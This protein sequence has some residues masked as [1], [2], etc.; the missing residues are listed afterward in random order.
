MRPTWTARSRRS[1]GTSA[2]ASPRPT[3]SEY[4][5]YPGKGSYLAVFTATDDQGATTSDTVLVTITNAPPEVIS[6]TAPVRVAPGLARSV[7]G[8]GYDPGGTDTLSGVLDFGDGSATASAAPGES[9]EHA[10]A[11]PGTYTVTYTV[12]DGQGG[13][14]SGTTSVL[15]KALS[16]EAGAPRTA[17][18]GELLDL[19]PVPE[20]QDNAD[21]V[22]VDFGDGSAPLARSAG[23]PTPLTHVYRN[24]GTYTFSL[25]IRNGVSEFTDTTQVTVSNVAPVLTGV[26]ASG[27]VAPGSSASFQAFSSDAGLDDVLTTTWAFGDGATGTG[28]TVN[29]VFAAPGTYTVA[30]TVTDD[31]GAAVTSSRVVAVAAGS[32]SAAIDSR[33]TDF[34]LA[35]NQNYSA[36]P[37]LTFY[38]T[39][40]VAT[41]GVVE[42]PG[43]GLSTPFTVAAGSITAVSLA[44]EAQLIGPNELTNENKAI[45]VTAGAEVTVYGLN[46]IPF[47]TDA[48]LG[49]PTD[50]LGT[51]YR[52]MSYESGSAQEIGVVATANDTTVTVTPTVSL[53]GFNAG[54]PF[55][56]TLDIGEVANLPAASG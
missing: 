43:L 20:L 36:P 44:P 26:A 19:T 41:S 39:S 21:N 29:H 34:W 6:V 47:T 45:H 5:R 38:V 50:S 35:F 10:W 16:I 42:V 18:E 33:G 17:V 53:G 9:V 22:V 15:V 8:Y 27:S 32:G 37:E 2:T 1:A 51:D 14:A 25:T 24:Q 30:A 55:T 11:A 13:T 52:V 23:D 3:L 4:H 56:T 28:R 48:F 12:S 31:S 40:D 49:L 7:S 46:R 54:Q